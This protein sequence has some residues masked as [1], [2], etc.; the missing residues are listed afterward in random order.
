M[1]GRGPFEEPLLGAFS[2]LA[3]G[4]G[5]E[6][7]PDGTLAAHRYLNTFPPSLDVPG[8]PPA[9]AALP[10]RPVPWNPPT[11]CRPRRARAGRPW[12]YLTFGTS[13]EATALLMPVADALAGLDVDVLVAAGATPVAPRG[14]GRRVRVEPFVPQA[15]LMGEF[16]LVVHHGGSGTMLAAAAHAVPQLVI[17]LG[18][19]QLGN[20]DAVRLAGIGARLDAARLDPAEVAGTAARLLAPGP[21]RAAADRVAAEIA[22]LPEPGRV[23]ARA[24]SWAGP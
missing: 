15:E 20:A 1:T 18:A 19:D 4:Y 9:P 10:V 24:A 16:S 12:V 23:A 21:H 6:L 5:V 3:A 14:P 17:P 8:P 11:P 2:R 13:F 22:L 7:P